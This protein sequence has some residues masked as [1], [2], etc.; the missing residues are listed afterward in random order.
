[1]LIKKV[2]VF[3]KIRRHCYGVCV[4]VVLVFIAFS[5]Q[6]S[7]SMELLA[8]KAK[9]LIHSFYKKICYGSGASL[10]SLQATLGRW[11]PLLPGL[12]GVIR[13]DVDR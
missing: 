7:C 12:V 11:D 4:C 10:L 3:T 8:V 6:A 5:T 2:I 9:L 13:K 1:M